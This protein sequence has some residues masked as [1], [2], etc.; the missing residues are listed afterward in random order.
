VSNVD[1]LKPVFFGGQPHIVLCGNTDDMEIPADTFGAFGA[2]F[3]TLDC[4]KNIGT[5]SKSTFERFKLEPSEPSLVVFANADKP[6][7]IL[8]PSAEAATDIL[9]GDNKAP[10]LPRPSNHNYAHG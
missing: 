5:S 7:Q 4:N 8:L 9:A 2:E 1:E 10:P 3:V 6:K